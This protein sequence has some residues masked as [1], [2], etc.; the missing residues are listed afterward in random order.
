MLLRSKQWGQ[1]ELKF[2]S[3]GRI[4]CPHLLQINRAIHV[5]NHSFE[6][7][8]GNAIGATHYLCEYDLLSKGGFP[9]DPSKRPTHVR[10]PM[11]T[12]AVIQAP[13]ILISTMA[14]PLGMFPTAFL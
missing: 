7:V 2:G 9:E 3:S 10:V 13:P 4:K 1:K 5:A 6:L 11:M 12:R 8:A 14:R